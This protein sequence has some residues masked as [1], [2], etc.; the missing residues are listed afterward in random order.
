MSGANNVVFIIADDVGVDK[1]EAY[2]ESPTAGPTPHLDSLAAQGVTFR[3]AWAYPVCSS[4]RASMLTGLHPT[5]HGVGWFISSS[6][7]RFA[8][9]LDP[10]QQTLPKLLSA[11]GIRT[12]AFGKWHLVGSEPFPS[13]HPN[14]AGFQ[15]YSGFLWGGFW[16]GLGYFFWPKTVNGTTANTATYATTDTADD[17]I[18]ALGG[19]EPFF[20]WVGFVAAHTPYEEPPPQLHSQSLAGLPVAGNE[21]LYHQEMVEAMDR[22]IGRILAAVDFSDTT[23][24]FIGDNGTNNDA[25][26]P[27]FLAGRAKFTVYEGGLNVPLIVAGQ[28]VA[29]GAGGQQSEALIQGTDLFATILDLSGVSGSAADSTSLVPHLSDPIAPSLRE[30][31]YSEGFFPNGG[32]IDPTKHWRAARDARYK[33][34][35]LAQAPDEFYDLVTDPFEYTNLLGTSLEPE[36]QTAYDRL[37]A[38]IRAVA[39]PSCLG[40]CTGDGVVNSLDFVRLRQ[41]F[42]NDCYQN[43]A[44]S[45][46]CDS[47]GDGS[48]NTADFSALR[49]SFGAACLP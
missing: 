2:A 41:E 42:G 26:E 40:D 19:S 21:V 37:D 9:G 14:L 44:L 29:A 15:H 33:I 24:I 32:P 8:S 1:I 13:V 30:A 46:T 12:A 25:V 48:V 7:P 27:P 39:A 45:C 35:R 6:D 34:V 31:V 22:E 16:T 5:R 20:L 47:D 43:S 18:V 38:A 4:S 28:A 17:V 36:Q 23:V 49:M 10:S 11:A 3:N